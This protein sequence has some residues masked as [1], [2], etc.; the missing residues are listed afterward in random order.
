M[1]VTM[2]NSIQDNREERIDDIIVEQ[3]HF[4]DSS[5]EAKK[6]NESPV[7]MSSGYI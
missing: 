1:K 2:D 7:F 6:T 3:G 5:K 4:S